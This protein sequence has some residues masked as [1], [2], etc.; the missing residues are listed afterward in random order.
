MALSNQLSHGGAIYGI[1]S[2]RIKQ[3]SVYG[4]TLITV[5]FLA[6]QVREA[7]LS[8]FQVREMSSSI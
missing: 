6:M 3:I 7:A 1:Y 4:S 5:P 8:I 2:S